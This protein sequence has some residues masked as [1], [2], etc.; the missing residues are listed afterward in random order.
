MKHPILFSFACFFLIISLILVGITVSGL[1]TLS[2]MNGGSLEDA[3]SSIAI[4]IVLVALP[5]T[6]SAGAAFIS[7]VLMAFT[8]RGSSRGAKIASGILLG[9]ALSIVLAY[10]CVLLYSSAASGS[11]DASALVLPGVAFFGSEFF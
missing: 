10:L 6:G 4:A 9:I 2:G 11:G 8:F 5:L 1:V 3:F 7:A